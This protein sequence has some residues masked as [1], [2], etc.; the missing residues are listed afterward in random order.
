[1]MNLGPQKVEIAELVQ[2]RQQLRTKA[3]RM[4]E[5]ISFRTFP[6]GGPEHIDLDK[7]RQAFNDLF[8]AVQRMREITRRLEAVPAEL[9]GGAL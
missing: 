6:N 7:V 8:D 9:R 3:E 5:E 1:M 4:V 2:E